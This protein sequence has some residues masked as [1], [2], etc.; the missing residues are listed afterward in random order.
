[1]EDR[2]LERERLLFTGLLA[3]AARSVEAI[4]RFAD[5]TAELDVYSALAD[6]AHRRG[7]T[8]PE[9]VDDAVLAIEGGRHP[10][11]DELLGERFVPND[12]AL[13]R[14]ESSPS[15]SDSAS[16]GS[17]AERSEASDTPRLALITGPNMAGKSTFI[18]QNALLVLLASIGSYVPADR[19]TVGVCDRIFTRVGADDALHRGQS[20]FM[21]EMTET[22]A[23]LNNATPRS[24]V[25][26]DEIGR[27]TSTLDGLSLAWAITEHLSGGDETPGPRTLFATHYHELTEL[28][29]R[30]PGRVRNLHVQVREWPDAQGH[31]EIIFV[32]RIAPG[33][34]DRSYGVH[35]ARLAGV[36]RGVTDRAEGVLASL[37][38]QEGHRVESSRVE[39][40]KRPPDGQMALFTEYLPHPVVDR[41]REMKIDAL[42]PMQAFDVLRRLVDDV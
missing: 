24:L 8:R 35:V 21:V 20:T 30:L 14:S 41:L 13:G 3:E 38:V 17:D 10:V 42:S 23:I 16:P 9:I 29:E 37:S 31:T 11:L 1:A 6:K 25:I 40:P 34:A 33:R 19:A 4:G 28:E 15:G 32:H 27:G 2:A 39:P 18:R 22:A 36:P 7:W 26:L 5:A 12:V